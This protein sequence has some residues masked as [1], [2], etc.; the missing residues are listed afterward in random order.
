MAGGENG[1]ERLDGV[2]EQS[3]GGLRDGSST[4]GEC[5]C[6][7]HYSGQLRIEVLDEIFECGWGLCSLGCQH[8]GR[9][10]TEVVDESL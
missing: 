4:V 5:G 2:L 7:F 8:S 3:G 6:C 9:L 10:H 1:C